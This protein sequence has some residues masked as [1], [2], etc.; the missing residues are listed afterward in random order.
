M[1][2]SIRYIIVIVLILLFAVF[3]TIFLVRQIT[4]DSST[5]STELKT[6][7]PA[8]FI[9]KSN[10]SVTWTQQGRLLGDDRHHSVRIS[11]N[12]NERR[13][14]LLTGYDER[15]EKSI[16][17]P[18][19]KQAYTEFM[20]A[21]EKLNFGKERSVKQTDVRGACPTA[22]RY[23]YQIHEGSDEKQNLW[24]DSCAAAD[25]T[26]AGKA[27]TVRVLFQAQ[28]TGYEKLTAGVQL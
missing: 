10:S 25:G 26:F 5:I 19:N 20:I 28:I 3:G 13:A 4:R 17:L 14:D 18:N 24:S 7:H 21:L 6:V 9:D 16:V 12:Q 11:I 2:S 15:I 1:G 8:D 22:F 23:I 27:D